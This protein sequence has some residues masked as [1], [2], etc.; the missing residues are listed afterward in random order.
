M[1]GGLRTTLYLP[2]VYGWRGYKIQDH[3][4][5]SYNLEENIDILNAY[6]GSKKLPLNTPD[7][8]LT[9]GSRINSDDNI[10]FQ[11]LANEGTVK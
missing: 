8:V 9:I 3:G 4:G 5:Q 1:Y 7:S 2:R 11:Y 6:N 10:I